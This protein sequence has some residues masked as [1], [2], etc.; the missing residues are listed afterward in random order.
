MVKLVV[1]QDKYVTKSRTNY[2]AQHL[3]NRKIIKKLPVLNPVF[4]DNGIVIKDISSQLYHN[5]ILD[6]NGNVYSF[7]LNYHGQSGAV[8]DKEQLR[9]DNII[10]SKD[11]ASI[12][13]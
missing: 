12:N 5:L 9:F 7:G 10:K 13:N 11:I 4:N 2:G 3:F 6:D 1:I 8:N